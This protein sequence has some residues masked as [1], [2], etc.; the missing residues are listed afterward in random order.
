VKKSISVVGYGRMGRNHARVLRALGHNVVTIDP[1]PSRGADTLAAPSLWGDI[2]CVA[3]P[4]DQLAHQATIALR[5]GKHVLVEKPMATS[6]EEAAALMQTAADMGVL[7]A[8]GYTER[9]NPALHVL[10][11]HLHLIGPVRQITARRLGPLDTP[12]PVGVAADLASHD[13]DSLRFLGL[14][15]HVTAMIG[16]ERHVTL[17]LDGLGTIEASYDSPAKVRTLVVTGARATL[18]LDYQAQAVTFV[19]KHNTVALDVEPAEPLRYQWHEFI[20]GVPRATADDGL[21]VLAEL[22]RATAAVAA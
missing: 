2:A 6:F 3:V 16:D 4:P 14:T 9:A 1:D 11:A 21:V 12:S 18:E 17:I 5:Q 7:L 15:P 22:D 20:R 13:L 19:A 10:R 8:V